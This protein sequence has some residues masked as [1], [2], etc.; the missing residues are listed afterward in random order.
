MWD[1]TQDTQSAC[2]SQS[3]RGQIRLARIPPLS[4]A[5]EPNADGHTISH[6]RRRREAELVG[7]EA[8]AAWANGFFAAFEASWDKSEFALEQSGDLA[9]SRYIYTARYRSREDGSELG[10]TGKGTC[11]YRRASTGEWLL[12]IDSWSLNE[13]AGGEA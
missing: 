11:V 7:K 3:C 9:V 8:I 13:T 10:E 2:R 5:R 4:A 12:M 6:S 1:S